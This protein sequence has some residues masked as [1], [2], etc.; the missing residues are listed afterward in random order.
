MELGRETQEGGQA[1]SL[2]PEEKA[3]LDAEWERIQEED[4][5]QVDDAPPWLQRIR[6]EEA[7]KAEKRAAKQKA[8]GKPG[9]PP[10]VAKIAIVVP[11]GALP[12]VGRPWYSTDGVRLFDGNGKELKTHRNPRT[13]VVYGRF[14]LCYDGDKRK[15]QKTPLAR[16][17]QKAKNAANIEKGSTSE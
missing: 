6:A 3:E 11:P 4:R 15:Y 5:R 1:V 16:E 13:G 14:F 7:R 17:F 9:P 10:K 12:L 2:T 8:A